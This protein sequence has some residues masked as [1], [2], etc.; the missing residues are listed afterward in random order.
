MSTGSTPTLIALPAAPVAM[1][2]GVTMPAVVNE[3]ALA[4]SGVIAMKSGP[5]VTGTGVP[6]APVA[7]SMGVTVPGPALAARTV[8]PSGVM[9]TNSASVPTL[10]ALPGTL[11]TVL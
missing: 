2:M 5:G 8:L 4:T 1:L 11:V 3:G 7:A 9:A 10:I 6:R